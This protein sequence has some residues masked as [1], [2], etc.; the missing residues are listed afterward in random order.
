MM[1]QWGG[2]LPWALW[3]PSGLLAVSALLLHHR[4]LGAQ[5]TARAVFWSNLI[6]GTLIAIS[7]SSS[8]RMIAGGL[9]I[10]TGS[11][12]LAVGRR[13]LDEAPGPFV[14]VAFRATL[15]GI[16]VMALADAQSLLLFG[17]LSVAEPSLVVPHT[18]YLALSFALA[19]TVGIVGIYRLKLWGVALN[20]ATNCA[21][22]VVALSGRLALPTPLAWAYTATAALQLLATTPLVI[23]LARGKA[24]PSAPSLSSRS[25]VLGGAFVIA[26]MALACYGVLAQHRLIDF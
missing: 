26:L 6:L 13:G 2:H 11:A 14:P 24:R 17:A 18:N 16:V 21:L 3:I 15:I 25:A 22:A 7:S 20:V 4:S 5:L 9:A 12:L 19:L 8:E 10:A 1:R 23:A